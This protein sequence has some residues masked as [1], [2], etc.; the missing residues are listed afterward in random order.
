VGWP[1]VL[2]WS[3]WLLLSVTWLR[4]RLRSYRFRSR[5]PAARLRTLFRSAMADQ[6]WVVS[7]PVPVGE[8]GRTLPDDARWLQA[9]PSGRHIARDVVLL[10]EPLPRG[11]AVVIG[12]RRPHPWGTLVLALGRSPVRPF[13]DAVTDEDGT[14]VLDRVFARPGLPAPVADPASPDP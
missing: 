13:L 5:L 3:G 6:N 7:P 2:L 4:L 9:R 14:V 10:L 8:G 11:A 1:A 12:Y